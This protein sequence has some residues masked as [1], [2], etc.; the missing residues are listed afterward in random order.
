MCWSRKKDRQKDPD[1]SPPSPKPT[2]EKSGGV[3]PPIKDYKNH[4]KRAMKRFLVKANARKMYDF[5]TKLESYEKRERRLLDEQ[6]ALSNRAGEV[7]KKLT[8]VRDKKRDLEAEMQGEMQR[9]RVG[10]DEGEDEAGQVR[11]HLGAPA[12]ED[13][14]D[15]TFCSAYNNSDF[16]EDFEELILEDK[17]SD[18]DDDE[19]EYNE[20]DFKSPTNGMRLRASMEE[21]MEVPSSRKQLDRKPAGA[22]ESQASEAEL[23]KLLK[24]NTTNVL[25]GKTL[26]PIPTSDSDTAWRFPVD[27]DLFVGEMLQVFRQKDNSKNGIYHDGLFAGKNRVYCCQMQGQFKRKPNGPI[28][29]IIQ[30]LDDTNKLGM[31]SKRFAKIWLSF[32]RQY[33]KQLDMCLDPTPGNP[34]GICMPVSDNWMGVIH[35]P[36]GQEPP[37]LGIRLPGFKECRKLNGFNVGHLEDP[38]LESTYTLEFYSQNLDMLGW[39]VFNIPVLPEFSLNR[40]TSGWPATPSVQCQGFTVKIGE[41]GDN[42]TKFDRN[43]DAVECGAF[44]NVRR[45]AK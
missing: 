12:L 3:L 15:D 44:L 26:R 21:A 30:Y 41:Q 18:D 32:G 24:L 22:V 17:D 13:A 43:T 25:H 36:K 38:N 31:I 19:Y 23:I 10:G 5:E 28:C 45:G 34:I 39:K 11:G 2:S 9:A 33:E 42:K 40:F 4:P 1:T 35:T 20:D 14:D 37:K 6:I 8:D 7:A 29:L 16:D 27:S